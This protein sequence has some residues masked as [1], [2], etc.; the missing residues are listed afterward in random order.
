LLGA[1]IFYP[2]VDRRTTLNVV[3][4]ITKALFH[5]ADLIHSEM[6]TQ[7]AIISDVLKFMEARPAG[8]FSSRSGTAFSHCNHIF[9]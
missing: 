1:D 4:S 5:Y 3:G 7:S 8:M 9:A 6:T 2:H